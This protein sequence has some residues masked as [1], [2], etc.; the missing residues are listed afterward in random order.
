[1]AGFPIPE[2]ACPRFQTGAVPPSA[3]LAA[4]RSAFGPPTKAERIT[5][6]TRTDKPWRNS[7]FASTAWFKSC[8][9]D[10]GVNRSGQPQLIAVFA[11]CLE[12]AV[13]TLQSSTRTTL[14]PHLSGVRLGIGIQGSGVAKEAGLDEVADVEDG[15]Q[16]R[17]GPPGRSTG[18]RSAQRGAKG[19]GVVHGISPFD[20]WNRF[21]IHP[22]S[23]AMIRRH[24]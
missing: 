5:L 3:M 16:I 24:V 14:K 12:E 8:E 19:N 1:M 11:R 10:H 21:S 18:K 22:K 20:S 13:F 6:T 4:E 2:E 7:A 9:V 23:R 15:N 17:H